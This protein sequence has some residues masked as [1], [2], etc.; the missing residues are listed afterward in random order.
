[1]AEP[2]PVSNRRRAGDNVL[3]NVVLLLVGLG[4]IAAVVTGDSGDDPAWLMALMFLMVC[5]GV[6]RLWKRLPG[7]VHAFRA[8]RTSGNQQQT[9]TG[10]EPDV[11]SEVSPGG[12]VMF[13]CAAVGGLALLVWSVAVQAWL[14][15]PFAA[16][17]AFVGGIGLKLVNDGRSS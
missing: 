16:V 17:I 11:N 15:V 9:R 13:T 10:Y 14:A 8:T 5:Y 7:D 3:A 1:M 4:A 6:G 2:R 12:V